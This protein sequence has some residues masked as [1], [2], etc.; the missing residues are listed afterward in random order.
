VRRA[1][2][3]GVAAP[4]ARGHPTALALHIE[5]CDAHSRCRAGRAFQAHCAALATSLADVI[6][7]NF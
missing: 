3:R 7:L 1:T 4:E 2:T 5:G 6:V